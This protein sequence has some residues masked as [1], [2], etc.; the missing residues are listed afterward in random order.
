[1]KLIKFTDIFDNTNPQKAYFVA[2]K[3]CNGNY[4]P[5]K[6]FLYCDYDDF[7]YKFQTDDGIILPLDAFAYV[8]A[9]ADMFGNTEKFMMTFETYMKCN[10]WCLEQNN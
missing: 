5:R 4:F 6:V 8:E 9:G 7:K 1:M 10:E 2:L 3:T